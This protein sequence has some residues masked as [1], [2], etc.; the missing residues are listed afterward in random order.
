MSS[1]RMSLL[2]SIGT[3]IYGP[4]YFRLAYSI[5]CRTQIF[6]NPFYSLFYFYFSADQRLL[7][8]TELKVEIMVSIDIQDILT[9]YIIKQHEQHKNQWSHLRYLDGN[10]D[11]FFTFLL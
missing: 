5:W 10:S 2:T 7:I 1:Q 9:S 8:T 11:H 6:R 3:I 4:L